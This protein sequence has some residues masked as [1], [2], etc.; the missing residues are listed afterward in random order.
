MKS[1]IW[2]VAVLGAAPAMAEEMEHHSHHGHGG[3]D[4]VIVDTDMALDDVRA[5]YALLAE[6]GVVVNGLATVEGSASLGRGTDNLVG[7]LESCGR[8]EVPVWMGG[9]ATYAEAPVWRA[10]ADR[11]GS[12]GFAPPRGSVQVGEYV[13]GMEPVLERHQGLLE[14]LALGPLTNLVTLQEAQPGALGRMEQI[15]IPAEVAQD[16]TVRSWNFEYDPGSARRVFEDDDAPLVLLDISVGD[17][18]DGLAVLGGLQGPAAGASWI[19]RS[20]SA[21]PVSVV[22]WIIYDELVVAAVAGPD[23]VEMDVSCYR[24]LTDGDGPWRLKPQDDGNV[25]VARFKDVGAAVEYL[26]GRWET[27]MARGTAAENQEIDARELLRTFHGH[28]GP[29]VVLGYRMG[30]EALRTLGSGGHFG[31]SAQVHSP[32]QPPRS[33]LIDGVQLGSGCTLGK[34]NIEVVEIDGAARALFTTGDGEQVTVS[35]KPDVPDLVRRLVEEKG[36]EAAGEELLDMDA[37]GLFD[38]AQPGS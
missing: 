23:L 17:D 1:L 8:P 14:Y 6:P 13:Q 29:Y 18:L 5:I 31:L 7:M 33:C 35:L 16:G 20:L 24:L 4:P 37:G 9:R 25:L 15:W 30:R 28:L 27:E 34:G 26:R 21:E 3:P 10:R 22:H 2:L 11:L 32:L 38:I 36:V 12:A 19:E